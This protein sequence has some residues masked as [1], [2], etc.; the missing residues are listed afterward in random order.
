MASTAAPPGTAAVSV[1]ATASPVDRRIS[2]RRRLA[3]LLGGMAVA[4]LV[5]FVIADQIGLQRDI[6]LVFYVA[7]VVALFVGWSRDTGQSLRE[8]VTRRWRLAV[9]LG[10][11][12][13][14]VGAATAV[15]AEDGAP[16][17]GGVEFIGA[18]L[19]R[20]V[21]YGAADGLLLSAFPILVVFAAL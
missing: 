16:H 10:I 1:T 4:C 18:L 15:G 7:A 9:G 17:P 21:V 6:Y 8:M 11:V 12:F 5:P 2:L 14:G 3:W 19:W 13:A 20:G